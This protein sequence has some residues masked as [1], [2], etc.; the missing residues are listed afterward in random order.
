MRTAMTD[1]NNIQDLWNHQK[2]SASNTTASDIIAKSEKHKKNIKRNHIFTI[3][4]IS[5]TAAILIGYLSWVDF[6]EWHLFT[7][8]LILMIVML[9]IRILIEMMSSNKFRKLNPKLS[10]SD[11]SQGMIR[12]Y[13]WRKTIHFRITPI[14][15]ISY[16]IGF[17]MILPT[18]KANL[19]TGV[20][21]YC[22]ISG[23]GCLIG[24]GFFI[25]KKIKEELRQVEFLKSL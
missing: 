6:F 9:L 19:S 24:L 14:I 21:W 11:Y 12:F 4:I 20:Y 5:M 8:G 3:T 7:I 10:L 17:T 22:L 23:F 15:Y 18:L 1:F 2:G 13:Q 25:F 16:I